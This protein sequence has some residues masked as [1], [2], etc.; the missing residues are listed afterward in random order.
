MMNEQI[1]AFLHELDLALQGVVEEGMRFDLYPLGRA[2]LILYHNLNRATRDVDIVQMRT[3][4]EEKAI[5]LFGKDTDNA[6]RL[7]LYLELVPQGLPPIP[8]WFVK[9]CTEVAGDWKVLRVWQGNTHDLAV[10]KLK[11]YRPQ[12]RQDLQFLCDRSLLD[13]AE[14]RRSLEAAFIWTTEKDGDPDRERAFANLERVV[15]YLEGKSRSL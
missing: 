12:D 13:P 15:A 2:A 14:L 4:L 9:R 11:S 5:A 7:G 6:R 10:T 8:H 3:P 1:L